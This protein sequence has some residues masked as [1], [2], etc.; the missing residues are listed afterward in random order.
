MQFQL[1][2]LRALQFIVTQEFALEG[3]NGAGWIATGIHVDGKTGLRMTDALQMLK[4]G[5]GSETT[6]SADGRFLAAVQHRPPPPRKRNPGEPWMPSPVP[7]PIYQVSVL[8]LA[9]K[10]VVAFQGAGNIGSLTFST[11]GKVL[12]ACVYPDNLANGPNPRA[13]IFWE[14]ASGQARLSLSTGNALPGGI[15]ESR[16]HPRDSLALSPDGRTVAADVNVMLN[17][18][19]LDGRP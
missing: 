1:A 13:V 11:D 19:S 6:L 5:S 8:E 4:A 17:R 7:P 9:T 3:G 16:K 2:E 14:L 12:S 15:E 18:V 10:K